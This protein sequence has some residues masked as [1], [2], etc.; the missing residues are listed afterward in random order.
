MGQKSKR[1]ETLWCAAEYK[2]KIIEMLESI[3]NIETLMKIYRFIET[4]LKIQNGEI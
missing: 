2:D 4:H 3:E 1:N